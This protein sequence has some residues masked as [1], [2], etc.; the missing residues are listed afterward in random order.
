M[1]TS[2][3][4]QCIAIAHLVLNSYAVGNHMAKNQLPN[5]VVTLRN[6][7]SPWFMILQVVPY[8][9]DFPDFRPG[10]YACLGLPGSASRCDAA[11]PEDTGVD[12]NK[13]IKRAFSIV[14]S[15]MHRDYL[16]FYV[17]LVPG[18]PL[19]PRLRNLEIGDRIWLSK[20]PEG[21]YTCRDLLV[22]AG[23]S[24]ILCATGAGLA[25]FVSM[26]RT[27]LVTPPPPRVVLIH[28]VRHSWDLGYRSTLM[29]MQH[30]SP[31]FTYLPVV[32]RPEDEV[33]LW[34]G[35][36]GRVQDVWNSGVIEQAW[37]FR[38]DPENTDVFL[39]GNPGMSDSMLELLGREGFKVDTDSQLGQVH[40]EN[41]WERAAEVL[42]EALDQLA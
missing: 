31:N 2:W 12:P 13:L 30:L 25:P 6:E 11:E 1:C 37:G 10:Q 36:T 16:E 20:K 23:A 33:A 35:E 18:G 9:W 29:A 22:R 3:R 40:V 34:K 19:T 27:H 15:P 7:V 4:V 5:A 28:S 41:Q 21:S 38:P 8:G 14:S 26:L 17:A 42:P 24:V 39:C 32:S